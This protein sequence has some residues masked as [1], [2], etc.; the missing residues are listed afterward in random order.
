MPI[1]SYHA[2]VNFPFV[3]EA[4]FYGVE[5][6]LEGFNA[7]NFYAVEKELEEFCIFKSD[8]SLGRHKLGQGA[9]VVSGPMSF[10]THN[11]IWDNYF[12]KTK[13]YGLLASPRTGMHVHVSR[14][15]EEECEKIW[16]LM[17]HDDFNWM[18]EQVAG[19][20]P[21]KFS[22]RYGFNSEDQGDLYWRT[23]GNTRG[24]I[25]LRNSATIEFRL[26][27]STLNREVFLARLGFVKCVCE[28]VK[29]SK[30]ANDFLEFVEF[31]RN[32]GSPDFVKNARLNDA[33]EVYNAD[34]GVETPNS[35]LDW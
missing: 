28:F 18:I 14:P 29:D 19:R 30:N 11:Y 2:K 24:R 6:E 13:D 21:N 9:E 32:N 3:G 23:Y 22:A 33:V 35:G 16:K 8:A 12:S 26:F 25:N 7:D 15:S 17:N 34:H 5:I 1:Q 20:K 31:A 10:A 27:N 4:P